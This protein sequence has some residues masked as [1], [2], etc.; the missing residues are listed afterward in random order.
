MGFKMVKIISAMFITF[1]IFTFPVKA[2]GKANDSV[3]DLIK[4]Y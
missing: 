1:F 3:S 4:H 2:D